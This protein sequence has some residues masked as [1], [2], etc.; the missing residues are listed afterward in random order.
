MS[1]WKIEF[2]EKHLEVEKKNHINEKATITKD[3][4]DHLKTQ[5][6]LMKEAYKEGRKS[7]VLTGKRRT[8]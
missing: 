4:I 6:R 2:L 8:N 1:Y 3:Y 7:R 5:L